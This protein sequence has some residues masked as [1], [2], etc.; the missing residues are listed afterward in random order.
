MNVGDVYIAC[1]D[2][3]HGHIVRDISLVESEG[4][5]IT[6]KF[7]SLGMISGYVKIDVFKLTKVRYYKPD[8]LPSWC[9]WV[10]NKL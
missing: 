2:S 8:T 6:E 1:D 9:K 10:E 7:I 4:I 5:V 3:F